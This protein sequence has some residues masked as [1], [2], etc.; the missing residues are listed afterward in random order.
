[1][2]KKHRRFFLLAC[3]CISWQLRADFNDSVSSYPAIA[4]ALVAT[5]ENPQELFRSWQTED[6]EELNKRLE[7]LQSFASFKAIGGQLEPEPDIYS[8]AQRYQ[9]LFT[10]SFGEIVL[11]QILREKQEGLS[12]SIVIQHEDFEQ[13]PRVSKIPDGLL[14]TLQK[15]QVTIHWIG[16]A[17][18]GNKGQFDREQ[19][20]CGGGKSQKKGYFVYWKT[21][22]ISLL[23]ENGD[24]KF[25]PPELIYIDSAAGLLPIQRTKPQDIE[26]KIILVT[27]LKESPEF[28][29][30]LRTLNLIPKENSGPNVFLNFSYFYLRELLGHPDEIQ[31]SQK[32]VESLEN[33]ALR[34]GRLPSNHPNEADMLAYVQ[35]KRRRVSSHSSIPRSKCFN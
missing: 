13:L 3:L 16:E 18:A 30:E 15:D 31:S 17:K 33:F 1:M 6:F 26:E 28:K 23:D 4:N 34:L 7:T 10:G 8:L 9:S 22:G 12:G 35:K 5:F 2:V 29:G 11:N 20:F 19:A 14:Y 21:K 25:F 27:R 32:E 24:P